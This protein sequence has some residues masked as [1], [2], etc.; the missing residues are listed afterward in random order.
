MRGK[1]LTSSFNRGGFRVLTQTRNKPHKPTRSALG[2]QTVLT[3]HS[4]QPHLTSKPL[5]PPPAK[6]I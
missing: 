1:P 5:Y 2:T 4:P 6:N 3:P